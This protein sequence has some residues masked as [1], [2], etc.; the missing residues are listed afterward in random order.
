MAIPVTFDENGGAIY[1]GPGKFSSL[2]IGLD[3]S[4]DAQITIYDN[5]TAA[6]GKEVLPTTIFDASALGLNGFTLGSGSALDFVNGLYVLVEAS[7]GGAFGGT[8]EG[9]LGI[10][11]R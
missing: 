1:A 4:N 7:G 5:A 10:I 3:G 2:F 9:T 8:L 6:S 11:P